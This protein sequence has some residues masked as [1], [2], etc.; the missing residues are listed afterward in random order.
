[1]KPV[2]E[3]QA[4]GPHGGRAVSSMVTTTGRGIL[5]RRRLQMRAAALAQEREQ[6]PPPPRPSRPV[7]QLRYM[8]AHEVARVLRACGSHL[9]HLGK[10]VVMH[11]VGNCLYKLI[12]IP[13]SSV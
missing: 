6:P 5:N 3:G 1:M 12:F 2:E 8:D 10:L 13:Q 4:D 9:T 7:A 11:V